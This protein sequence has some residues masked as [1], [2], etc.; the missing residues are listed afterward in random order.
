MATPAGMQ[1]CDDF[2][3]FQVALK[4][5][6]LI[7]DKIVYAIN[8]SIP[9]TSFKGQSDAKQNC[10]ELHETIK[11]T[12]DAREEAVKQCILHTQQKIQRARE[13]GD[14]SIVRPTQLSNQ[15]FN[16]TTPILATFVQ[17]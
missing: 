5:M 10:K 16:K 3:Q 14:S 11:K 6:R 15:S 7:D 13:S 9:T 4:E 2:M 12:Y 1:Q 17:K 8:Q